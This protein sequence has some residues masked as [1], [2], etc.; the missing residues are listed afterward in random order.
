[1]RTIYSLL[2]FTLVS[3][4]LAGAQ[5]WTVEQ[6]EVIDQLGECWDI[7]MDGV[8]QGTPEAWVE[9]CTVGDATFWPGEFA[10]PISVDDIRRAWGTTAG[11]D[12]NWIAIHPIVVRVDGDVAIMHFYGTWHEPSPEGVVETE[13]KRTEVFRRIDGRWKISV[14]HGTPVRPGS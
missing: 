6:Q 12:I 14:G 8:R 10:A 2:A 4:D 3:P 1:M 11:V 13:A 7:W 9:Q 5:Q